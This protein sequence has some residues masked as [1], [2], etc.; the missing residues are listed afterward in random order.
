MLITRR[1]FQEQITRLGEVADVTVLDRPEPPTRDE[2]KKA[3]LGCSGIFAHITDLV[4]GEI[5]DMIARDIFKK[6]IY[7]FI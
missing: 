1:Q 2:L 7:A 6:M 3:V 5:T 4:D